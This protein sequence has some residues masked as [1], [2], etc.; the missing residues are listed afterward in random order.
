VGWAEAN[1]TT[2][3]VGAMYE[4]FFRWVMNV[5]AGKGSGT[6]PTLRA[7][8]STGSRGAI[9]EFDDAMRDKGT[10]GFLIV[11]AILLIITVF[12]LP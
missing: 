7:A 5:A 2:K 12:W 8:I 4:E 11:Y 1:F 10:A 6:S 9:S 3:R